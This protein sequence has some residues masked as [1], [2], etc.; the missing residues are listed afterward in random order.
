M[1]AGLL[2]KTQDASRSGGNVSRSNSSRALAARSTTVTTNTATTIATPTASTT[3]NILE[4]IEESLTTNTGL[5]KEPPHDEDLSGLEMELERELD[6]FSSEKKSRPKG[7]VVP[8]QT[9]MHKPGIETSPALA[10]AMTGAGKYHLRAQ[11]Q[12]SSDKDP[13]PPLPSSILALTAATPGKLSAETSTPS[14]TAVCT[15]IP[16]PAPPPS[17]PLLS[18]LSRL[19]PEQLGLRSSLQLHQEGDGLVHT[20]QNVAASFEADLE[21]AHSSVPILDTE[22]CASS[23]T[24]TLATKTAV[25]DNFPCPPA[26]KSTST[27]SGL[28]GDQASIED[29]KIHKISSRTN[30]SELTLTLA[31][32]SDLGLAASRYRNLS[33]VSTQTAITTASEAPDFDD[34]ASLLTVGE[35][36]EVFTA[37]TAVRAAPARAE[38]INVR[39]PAT[40]ASSSSSGLQI[41]VG[42]SDVGHRIITPSHGSETAAAPESTT[43]STHIP[44]ATPP[45][46]AMRRKQPHGLSLSNSHPPALLAHII[47]PGSLRSEPSPQNHHQHI[48]N[49][50]I[51]TS[52]LSPAM[53]D[54]LSPGSNYHT[55]PPAQLSAKEFGMLPP[56]IQ[57]KVRTYLFLVLSIVSPI[58]SIAF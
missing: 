12:N 30:D 8:H 56:T 2:P 37:A 38:V 39:R 28:E 58:P 14:I 27:I 13:V 50:T 36:L 25:I 51:P 10:V 11:A 52:I 55:V 9:S 54:G 46:I 35:P 19:P 16:T 24:S 41:S 48:R 31:V 18:S 29:E 23:T 17:P 3:D 32:G 6:L 43:I 45:K 44:E 34:S 40:A 5:K 42:G 33:V 22:S 47:S 4:F 53:L 15:A 57:R 7:V 1:A 21:A 20:E 49:H 26:E